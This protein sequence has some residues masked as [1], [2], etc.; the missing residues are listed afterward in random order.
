MEEF[1]RDWATLIEDYG[2]VDSTWVQDIYEKREMWGEAYFQGVFLA[3]M[4]T[5]QRAESVNS[6]MKSY[7][8]PNLSITQFIQKF[9]RALQQMRSKFIENQVDSEVRKPV[10]R[11]DI[12][13][14]GL[15]KHAADICTKKIFKKIRKNITAEQ[16]LIVDDTSRL[17]EREFKFSFRQY[18]DNVET[19]RWGVHI[20]LDNSIFL[21]DC[22]MLQSKGIPCSHILSGFKSMGLEDFPYGSIHPRWLLE[23]GKRL[24]ISFPEPLTQNGLNQTELGC[25]FMQFVNIYQMLKQDDSNLSNVN[26][27]LTKLANEVEESNKK[28]LE[29]S[30][31]GQSSGTRNNSEAEH[32]VQHVLTDPK[33]IRSKGAVKRAPQLCSLCRYHH[34]AMS[35]SLLCHLICVL[36]F[37]FIV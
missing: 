13:L 35:S 2:V 25:V 31:H 16:R 33:R 22:M 3:G 27:L 32:V 28:K 26:D 30:D 4:T 36:L 29:Q 6:L 14:V 20:D 12:A 23:T 21:C 10:A 11:S 18:K 7:L 5:T 1:E 24:R 8:E 17:G 34:I 15:E 19:R 9:H 37:N